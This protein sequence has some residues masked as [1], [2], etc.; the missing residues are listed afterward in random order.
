MEKRR[1]KREEKARL[2]EGAL[3]GI[4]LLDI[5][6]KH[7]DNRIFLCLVRAILLFLAVYGTIVGLAASFELP[8]NTPLVA[9]TLL[10]LSIMSSFIYYNRITFYTGYVVVFI[11]LIIM[12]FAF[13]MYINSGFQAF[14]NEVISRYETFFSIVS[15]RVAEEQI[16]DRNLTVSVMLIFVGGVFSIFFNITISGYMD[17]PMTFLVSFLPLQFAFYIDIVPPRIYLVMLLAV[18]ISVAVLGRSGHY[19]LPYKYKKNLPF[20]RRRTKNKQTHYYHASGQGMI[21]MLGY[22]IILSAI[23]MLIVGSVFNSEFSTKKLSNAVKDVTDKYVKTVV[24]NGVTALFNRYDAVGG[25]SKG[26]LGGIRSVNPDYQ[27]D[28]IVDYVK[29][30]NNDMYLK[31]YTGVRY[32]HNRFYNT[33]S[34]NTPLTTADDII[35]F[36]DYVPQNRDSVHYNKIHIE[37]VGADKTYNYEP[38]I[39]FLTTTTGSPAKTGI[40]PAR[41][42]YINESDILSRITINPSL[43]EDSYETIYTPLQGGTNYGADS[44]EKMDAYKSLYLSYPSTLTETLGAVSNEARLTSEEIDTYPSAARTIMI[45]ENLKHFYESNFVYTMTPG[46]TPYNEDIV[47]HFLTK[48][49][50]G[51]CAHFASSA[52]LMLRYMGIPARYCEGYLLEPGTLMNNNKLSD[53]TTGWV[54]DNRDT[55]NIS[56]D[57]NS[58]SPGLYRIEL[59]DANAHSWVEIYVDGYG[60]IPYEMTP[61]AT[62]SETPSRNLGIFGIFAGL[63]NPTERLVDNTSGDSGILNSQSDSA[64]NS[65][66]ALSDAIDA[67]SSGSFA[68]FARSVGYLLL[69]FIWMIGALALVILLVIIGRLLIFEWKRR[70]LVKKGLFGDALLFEYRRYLKKWIKRSLVDS[71][72]PSVREVEQMILNKLND[73]DND[74]SK[75]KITGEELSELMDTLYLAGFSKTGIDEKT[76]NLSRELLKKI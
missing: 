14:L 74:N 52:T 58:S 15:G 75:I 39:P 2:K 33:F 67:A 54:Y 50:R 9:I 66:N 45:A 1:S 60:W 21:W 36:D 64:D 62:E 49:R 51:F 57:N 11:L 4:T 7:S 41:N 26:Q 43:D 29:E 71:K 68:Q 37:N 63:F 42:N 20:G 34:G 46:A 18:Y 23:V 59:S 30:N 61:P 6:K 69:P 24:V 76:Y 40:A 27:T 10:L 19:T 12:A 16:A 65:G 32:E 72:N 48:N 22:S 53:D 25:L 5:K 56:D 13:Y 47:E 38:Y 70:N 55:S 17:L 73:N 35:A 28:L 31:A 8:F 44:S 3:Y